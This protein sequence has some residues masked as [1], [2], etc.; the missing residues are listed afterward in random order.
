MPF[1]GVKGLSAFF[2]LKIS[3]VK[4]AYSVLKALENPKAGVQIIDPHALTM[5]EF[6]VGSR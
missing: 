2:C 1:E 5:S 3:S 6:F 4:F